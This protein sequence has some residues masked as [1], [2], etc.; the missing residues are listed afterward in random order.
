MIVTCPA[1]STRYLVDPASLGSEGRTVRC[2]RC[3]HSWMQRP[4][5]EPPAFP[6]EELEPPP[7]AVRPI[8]P[9]SNLP[10][11]PG[12]ARRRKSSNATWWAVLALVVGGLGLG[13]VVGREQVAALWPAVT[14]LYEAAGL[15]M[16]TLGSGLELRGVQ[17]ERRLENGATVLVIT[18]QIANV[19]ERERPVPGLQGTAFGPGR[20][21]LQS[22]EIQPSRTE[23]YPGEIA[24]FESVLRNPDEAISEIAISFRPR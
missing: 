9:G 3:A 5:V 10:A 24:T 18:G 4:P 2:A 17:S 11:R 22:W 6:R 23:L 21:V 14:P 15:S 7:A 16:E 19:S 8:P 1:C 20:R 12:H 13:L